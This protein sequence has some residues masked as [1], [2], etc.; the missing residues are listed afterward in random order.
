MRLWM[1]LI[2]ATI[3]LAACTVEP[4]P[5]NFGHDDCELCKMKLMDERFGAQLVTDKG[6]IFMFD[7]VNCMVMF[8]DSEE[9]QR[10]DYKYELIVDYSNPGELLDVH[11]TFFLKNKDVR[12]PMNSQIIALPDEETLDAYRDELDGGIYLGWGEIKTHFK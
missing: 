8:M 9:G 11:Y 2:F 1:I 3:W 12:T 5:I 6:R 7:D 10:H 4:R